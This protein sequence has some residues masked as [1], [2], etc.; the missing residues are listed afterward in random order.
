MVQ[1]DEQE[2]VLVWDEAN[3]RCPCGNFVDVGTMIQCDNNK[4]GVWQHL[5]CVLPSDG[6]SEGCEPE[7]PPSFYCELCR[8]ARCDPF[9]VSLSHPLLPTKPIVSSSKVENS[10]PLQTV[11]KTFTLSCADWDL[12]H[13]QNHDLQVWCV[14]L[15]DKV[16]FR[17]H[18]PAYCGL[19]INSVSVL[20]TNRPGTQLLSANGRDEGPRI[21]AYIREGINQLSLSA[22][23]ARDFCVGVRI[24]RRNSVK[25][26][27]DLIPAVT[28]GEDFED[29]L[30][31]L[32][33][34]INGGGGGGS[35]VD[36]DDNDS[37]LEIITDS[38][39]VSLRCPMSG[40]RI[41]VAGRFKPCLH[42]GCFDL[43]SFVELNQRAHKWQC[44][45]CLKNYSIDS[46]IIDPLFNC[47]TSSMKYMKEDVIEVEMKDNGFW[48]PK[49]EGEARFQE[50]WRTPRGTF[51]TA[52][53][54]SNHYAGPSKHVKL[55]ATNFRSPSAT[56]DNQ[57]Q[58]DGD[59]SFNQ[60][61]SD[62]GAQYL[63]DGDEVASPVNMVNSMAGMFQT[64]DGVVAN[65]DDVIVLSD[66]DDEAGEEPVFGSSGASVYVASD[67]HS[68]SHLPNIVSEDLHD[69]HTELPGL[70]LA[71]DSE[72]GSGLN[73]DSLH[74]KH[75][76][77]TRMDSF[78][79]QKD[80][81]QKLESNNFWAS[82]LHNI[83]SS[84]HG[85]YGGSDPHSVSKH[86]LPV[87]PTPVQV[88][89][90]MGLVLPS[91]PLKE[92]PMKG[93]SWVQPNSEEPLMT[94]KKVM[95]NT[96]FSLT[97]GGRNGMD[98]ALPPSS[99][100]SSSCQ[101]YGSPRKPRVGLDTISSTASVL[102]SMT[103]NG[104]AQTHPIDSQ[105]SGH[106]R[107]PFDTPIP[108]RPHSPPHQH[109]HQFHVQDLDSE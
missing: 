92:D 102:F 106:S 80:L 105:G 33:R 20:V 2:E 84:P 21:T 104:T 48:R 23:D 54:E 73:S 47:I 19:H 50:P 68:N 34:C 44:P 108:A 31:R 88:A 16:P 13:K 97:L 53:N 65:G 41:K 66:T 22:H 37:D 103:G 27:M 60:E 63:E 52:A 8:I 35:G 91:P 99:P 81:D 57:E 109:Y 90:G 26:V 70:A 58:E 7:I 42:M 86:P 17:M 10:N 72:A 32:R 36:D 75:L 87:Q 39:T 83:P 15:T 79:N 14:L 38:I 101:V 49:L 51:V 69:L 56:E 1:S 12:L 59:H 29:A 25:Q 74:F 85:Y 78:L 67:G 61:A 93:S 11:E 96:W 43:N 40:S 55:I 4:C 95:D 30:L 46:L 64:C 98:S 18:W 100:T 9:C 45:I 5:N 24:F 71:R 62:N 94:E 6:Y 76:P 28:K 77:S 82:Q 89:E 3:T 107:S